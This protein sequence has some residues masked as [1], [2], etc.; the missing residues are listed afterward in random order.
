MLMLML[1]N[2]T[3]VH[4]MEGDEIRRDDIGILF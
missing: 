4:G 3:S 2:M 1:R